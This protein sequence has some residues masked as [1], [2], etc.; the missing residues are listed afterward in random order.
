MSSAVG[1][2]AACPYASHPALGLGRR[3]RCRTIGTG[4]AG[5]GTGAAARPSHGAVPAQRA[6]AD[7]VPAGDRLLNLVSAASLTA[8]QEVHTHN[9][10]DLFT[11]F[12]LFAGYGS[13]A[14]AVFMAMMLA[15][16]KRMAWL[17]F[18]ALCGGYA[19]LSV[20]GLAYPDCGSTRSTGC[21]PR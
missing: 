4:A 2:P 8:R 20:W 5:P 3:A 12:M 15:R 17:V 16:H 7:L 6:G 19:A 14:A 1:T 21:P 10:G 11:P 18:M 13:A 9:S